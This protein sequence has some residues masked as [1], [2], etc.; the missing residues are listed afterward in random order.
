MSEHS[1]DSDDKRPAPK[2]S[3]SSTSSTSTSSEGIS[4]YLRLKPSKLASG[5]IS[6]DTPSSLK[7]HVPRSN[8][9]LINNT[10]TDY[11][12]KF[13]G[14]L[15]MEVR[16][17]EVYDTVGSSAVQNAIDGYN[18]TI[19]A[20][21]QTG[22]GKTFTITG[23]S[24]RY[25]DR[26]I[27]PRAITHLFECFK[28]DTTTMYSAYISYLEIY[29]ESGYDLLDS[30][31]ETTKLE[32]MKKVV[33]MENEDGNYHL[34]N[35]SLHPVASEEDALNC[36]F[37]G[38]TNRAISETD[39]NQASSRSHCIFTVSIEARPTTS[40]TVRR[41]KLHLVD[42]AGSERVSKTSSN[43]QTLR[44]AKYINSSLFFL[45]MVIVALHEKAKKGRTHIPYRNSMMTSVLRDSLGGNCKTVM[46][47]TISNERPHVDE[48]ISTCNFAQRVA[49]IKNVATV[50]EDLD[51]TLVIRRL[52]AEVAV[53]REEVRFLKGESGEGYDLSDEQRDDL[54]KQVVQ[55]VEDRDVH[56]QLSIGQM[57]LVKLRDAHA[58][59]KN[60][61]LE[62]S[63]K[64]SAGLS[65]S[66]QTDLERQNAAL[67]N[68]LQQRDNEI[69]ILVNMVK[70]GKKIPGSAGAGPGFDLNAE[71][72][73]SGRRPGPQVVAVADNKER[74]V[75]QLAE[76]L[77][78]GVP[79]CKD[80]QILDDPAAAFSHFKV[81]YPGNKAVEENKLLL[82]SKY[83]EAKA[84]GE[85]VNKARSAINYLKTTIEQLRRERAMERV[86]SEEK[87]GE[88]GDEQEEKDDGFV[89]HEEEQHRKSI[90]Q[91]KFVYKEN[92]NKLRELKGAIEHIQRL[93]EKSRVKMQTDF[94]AWYKHCVDFVGRYGS[95]AGGGAMMEAKRDGDEYSNDS[96]NTTHVSSFS[97]G[98]RGQENNNTSF[99]T[100]SSSSSSGAAAQ[101]KQRGEV[102]GP[103]LTGNKEADDDIMAF[104]KA[105]EELLRRNGQAKN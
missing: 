23:G 5:Y 77:V 11:S 41:S 44:E 103:K 22:S 95:G 91:E 96:M 21:G 3:T 56:A 90:E 34:K 38:D 29:N 12:F 19:F 2:P 84:T 20:Y 27:I 24:E 70:Q 87:G 45:E 78:S 69:A 88:A 1:Y 62:A 28:K 15:G 81:L 60:L 49:L 39:M 79:L 9:D 85:K 66:E 55:Y 98:G 40:D 36:L 52:K 63:S 61:V 68:S 4:I 17:E 76:K 30:T 83:G 32:D 54:K 47:A 82:K 105:K 102:T 58:I 18:S 43:G 42:L 35:L 48:S 64:A 59:F 80:N 53:L 25:V 86:I 99:N 46:I 6:Q 65:A 16:Q 71:A 92:F 100:Q 51:P 37:L 75:Q 74:I 89:D 57:T 7:F 73:D 8:D 33:M 26:G 101:P 10:R 93:L 97:G 13:N 67:K 72:K 50:N 94:D 31:H 14:V 104:Y